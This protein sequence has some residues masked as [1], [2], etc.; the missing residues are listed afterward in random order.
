MGKCLEILTGRED[1]KPHFII[2]RGGHRL[3]GSK[4]MRDLREFFKDVPQVDWGYLERFSTQT[5]IFQH[6]KFNIPNYHHGYCLDDNCRALLLLLMADTEGEPIDSRLLSTYL[7][8]ILYSQ[9]EKGWFRNFMSYDL[10][11]LESIGSEDSMGRTMWTLGYLLSKKRYSQFHDVTREIF[12]RAIHHVQSSRSI[13]AV[14]Y[15]TL[16]ILHFL[17]ANPKEKFHQ[18]L[19]KTLVQFIMKEYKSCRRENWHWYEEIISYDNAIIP[20][21]LLR[22]AKML[23]NKEIA[24]IAL[25]SVIFLDKILFRNGHL[26]TI[27]NNGW[28]RIGHPISEFGQQPIEVAS[29][30]MLY[31]E[32][33]QYQT[34]ID[35]SERI[36]TAFLWF[37]G[38]NDKKLSLFNFEQMACYD[39]LDEHGINKNQG[40]ESNISF[41]MSYL[42]A[43]K[44][45]KSP[46]VERY[47]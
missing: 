2:D 15:N 34:A 22:A 33:K 39:G 8:F 7:A 41:W 25:E 13:R 31:E 6:G 19:L 14:A 46:G 16:G 23:K 44:E 42:C 43:K 21:A 10:Q 30:I 5:G 37:L 12:D 45:W 38:K 36:R 11:F 24:D 17:E 4:N 3:K 26:S 29:I 47:S 27:G 32:L 28:Y 20:L 9:E 40:A 1:K 35:C 18:K